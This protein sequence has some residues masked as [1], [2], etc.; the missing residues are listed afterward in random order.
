VTTKLDA[1]QVNFYFGL[2]L[3]ERGDDYVYSN[4]DKVAPD[5]QCVNL[6][7]DE[8]GNY[9]PS[10]IVGYVLTKHLGVDTL[11]EADVVEGGVWSTAQLLKRG[12]L[13]DLTPDA[14][15]MLC[16]AQTHQD[17]GETWG[18]AVWSANIARD[19]YMSLKNFKENA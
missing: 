10:C 17:S 6:A 4:M 11:V 1:T 3:R 12:G 8:D 18:K 19:A 7:L 9:Q 14:F 15:I 16:T 13:L 2:A 5:C